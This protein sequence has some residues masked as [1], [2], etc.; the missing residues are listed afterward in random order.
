MEQA[1]LVKIL[2]SLTLSLIVVIACVVLG[3]IFR[4]KAKTEAE[5]TPSG[6][7]PEQQSLDIE[8]GLPSGQGEE[9]TTKAGSATYKVQPGDTLYGISLKFK[10]DWRDIAKANGIEDPSSLR[11]GQE[12]VIP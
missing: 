1:R 3:V 4:P 8:A 10:V 5:K 7:G 12:I 6:L 9:S 2:G 11:S